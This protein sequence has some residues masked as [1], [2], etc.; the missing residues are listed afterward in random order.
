LYLAAVGGMVLMA[1][2]AFGAWVLADLRDPKVL[3]DDWE[4]TTGADLERMNNE[5]ADRYHA[6][7]RAR[8]REQ[9][10]VERHTPR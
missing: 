1:L 4:G 6:E 3:P 10:S 2:C 7:E 9:Q 5:I 8:E